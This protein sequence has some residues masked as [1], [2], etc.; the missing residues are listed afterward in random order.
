VRTW[1]TGLGVAGNG[2]GGMVLGL[3]GI[4]LVQAAGANEAGASKGLDQTLRTLA[5]EP[6][7]K[8]LLLA[9]AVGLAA[10]GLYSFVEMRF[11]RV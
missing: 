7:G 5:A 8:V 10:Y 1:A 6:F 9:V 11:R 3:V 2:A 4:F